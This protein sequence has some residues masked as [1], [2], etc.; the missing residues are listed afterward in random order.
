VCISNVDCFLISFFHVS[1]VE[2]MF[3]FDRKLAIVH[4]LLS[5]K[6]LHSH[7]S[8]TVVSTARIALCQVR[9][10]SDKE[11]NIQHVEKMIQKAI[12][13][14]E[15]KVDMIIL[16]EIWNSPYSTASFPLYA[17]V[18]PP[19][20]ASL[21]IDSSLSPSTAKLSQLAKS[22]GIWII[23]GSIPEVIE[24]D[25]VRNIYNTC[26][27]LDSEGAIVGKHRKVHLF[28]IDIPGKMTFKESD[29]LS[30]GNKI[31]TVDSPFGKIGIGICYDMRFP[32]L[33]MIMREKG[34]R[35]ICYPGAFNM[36]TGPAH[37]ELL[38]RARAV[39]NQLFVVACSPARDTSARSVPAGRPCSDDLLSR[40]P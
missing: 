17:E 11:L 15:S 22:L 30:R 6:S 35:L 23:G 29:S 38:Q 25:Q 21:P 10:T 3:R 40:N 12:S 8:S 13:S 20:Q 2:W 27:V 32:E 7:M 4:L 14:S 31:T 28:D 16:P 19:V 36:V 9:V 39:D 5:P 1:L 24:E 18:V 34:C 26:V 37:W 33:A